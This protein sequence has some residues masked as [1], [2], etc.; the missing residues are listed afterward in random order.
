[1]VS[2][3]GMAQSGVEINIIVHAKWIQLKTVLWIISFTKRDPCAYRNN[4][5]H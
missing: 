5:P 3:L 4:S 1:M 2:T